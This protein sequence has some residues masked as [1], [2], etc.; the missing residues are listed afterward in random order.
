[1]KIGELNCINSLKSFTYVD[2]YFIVIVL[3]IFAF[4]CVFVNFNEE[5][6]FPKHL[7]LSFSFILLIKKKAIILTKYNIEQ[8]FNPFI[9]CNID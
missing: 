7:F 8:N 9:Y 4:E 3:W 6:L 2:D 1:M 5:N